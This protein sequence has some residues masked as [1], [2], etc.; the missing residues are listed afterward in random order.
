MMELPSVAQVRQ[1]DEVWSGRVH[2]R[3]VDENGHMSLPYYLDAAARTLWT[4]HQALGLDAAF[5]DGKTFFV[6]EQHVRY[7]GELTKGDRFTGHARFM[8]RSRSA[9]HSVVYLVDPLRDRLSC[10]VESVHVFVSMEHR[11]SAPI[12]ADLAKGI[13]A[14]ILIH[15]QLEWNVAGCGTL[16]R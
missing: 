4:R 2:K 9:M 11:R 13:D 14:D 16:W 15:A 1:L 7:V 6:A 3:Y 8:A 5:A 10:V 12:T